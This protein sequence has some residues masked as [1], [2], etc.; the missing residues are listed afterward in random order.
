MQE[1]YKNIEPDWHVVGRVLDALND[2]RP[3]LSRNN[4][5]DALD[6]GFLAQLNRRDQGSINRWIHVTSSTAVRRVCEILWPVDQ[7]DTTHNVGERELGAPII[8]PEEQVL[9]MTLNTQH[10]RYP[11][12]D[13]LINSQIQSSK[14]IET[15]DQ[16]KEVKANLLLRGEPRMDRVR[17]LDLEGQL[18]NTT[19]AMRRFEQEVGQEW[20]FRLL[21]EVSTE[22][23]VAFEAMRVQLTTLDFSEFNNACKRVLYIVGQVTELLK[24]LL[25]AC[26]RTIREGEA[27]NK[28]TTE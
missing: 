8:G 16:L 19:T 17:M 24:P 4:Y 21:N 12:R 27:M 11:W 6:I 10:L 1:L 15:V 5:H 23:P 9:G 2:L 18:R 22:F 7:I 14:L 20:F 26:E 25:A 13:V 3:E 28:E